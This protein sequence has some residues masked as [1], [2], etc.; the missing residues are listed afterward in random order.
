MNSRIQDNRQN[1]QMG[2]RIIFVCFC[3]AFLLFISFSPVYATSLSELYG[4]FLEKGDF[5]L[6]QQLDYYQLLESSHH[7]SSFYDKFDSRIEIVFWDTVLKFSPM[8]NLEMLFGFKQAYPTEYSRSTYDPAGTLAAL[9]NYDLQNFRDFRFQ[10]RLRQGSFE[11]YVSVLERRQKTNWNSSIFPDPPN[12]FAY[13][14]THYE[15]L[16]LGLR[17]LSEGENQDVQKSNLSLLERSLLAYGQLTLDARLRYRNGMLRRNASLYPVGGYY[18]DNYYQRLEYQYTPGFLMGYGLNDN[19]EFNGGLAFSFPYKYRYIY[20]RDT[21]TLLNGIYTLE[22]EL[23]V[24]LQLRYRP[25]ANLE[26]L[27]SSDMAYG[28][29]KLDYWKNSGGVVTNYPDKELEYFNVRPAVT[30]TYLIDN[31][32]VI[33]QD[34]FSRL[35]KRLLSAGQCLLQFKYLRDVT[36]LDK[37]DDNGAQNRIDPQGVFLYPIDLFMAGTENATFYTGNKSDTAANVLAQDYNLFQC[38]F[39]YGFTERF[40]AGAIV[41]H[42]TSSRFH[43]FTL[44]SSSSFDLKSRYYVVKPFWFFSIPCDWRL[45]ENSLLSFVWYYVPEYRT[46]IDI[47]GAAKE[48][49]SNTNY[50]SLSLALKI[51]F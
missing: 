4:D 18:F 26:V 48:F 23:S 34:K 45:G 36:S 50:Y 6:A 47:E 35:T 8:D 30:L 42:R 25:I 19:L 21:V 32:G 7:A 3:A 17:Y 46:A 12:Y 51:L 24:P 11:P 14:I 41:G 31:N 5:L 44:G 9:L 40:N 43:H 16:S 20:R 29:Q 37:E 22:N 1:K 39:L 15:D 38:S 33:T 2:L 28:R 27:L 10:L 13:I 49:R